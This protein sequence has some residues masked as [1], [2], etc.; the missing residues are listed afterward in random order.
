LP[1]KSAACVFSEEKKIDQFWG[2][3]RNSLSMVTL[4][5]N[6]LGFNDADANFSLDDRHGVR[7]LWLEL[8][9]KQKPQKT[10]VFGHSRD[11]HAHRV[12]LQL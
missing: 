4:Y 7:G 5:L 11:L 12:T 10:K 3:G 9:K 2:C 8:T 1:F 6:T